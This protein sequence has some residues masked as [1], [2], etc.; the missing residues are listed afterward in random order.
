MRR[1]R[2]ANKRLLAERQAEADG[3]NLVSDAKQ[4]EAQQ[5]KDNLDLY[6]QLKQLEIE[7]ERAA[8]WDG[9]YPVYY[10]PSGANTPNLMMQMP[11]PK[12]TAEK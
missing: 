3:I 7:K 1:T 10:M 6:V 9:R 11:M 4:Y 5:A 12:R 8:K 2:Y